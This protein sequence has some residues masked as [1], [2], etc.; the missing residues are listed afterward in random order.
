LVSE[1]WGVT[2]FIDG[3]DE[4]ISIIELFA[5][6]AAAEA[7]RDRYHGRRDRRYGVTRFEVFQ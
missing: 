2:Y 1:V 5:T 7:F 6:K 3:S 4:G